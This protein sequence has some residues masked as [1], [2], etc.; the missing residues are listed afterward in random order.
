MAEKISN[1]KRMLFNGWEMRYEMLFIRFLL[2]GFKE[3]N[4]PLEMGVL[5]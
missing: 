4:V 2:Q 5:L 3:K 1:L